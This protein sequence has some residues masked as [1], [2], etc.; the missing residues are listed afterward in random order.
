MFDSVFHGT[1][2]SG[3]L[4]KLYWHKKEKNVVYQIRIVP[5]EIM[6]M[7]LGSWNNKVKRPVQYNNY[8][9]SLTRKGM[10]ENDMQLY[11]WISCYLTMVRQNVGNI[12]AP[13]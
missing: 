11:H 1:N 7:D 9:Y 5:R 4:D 2:N 8:P 12:G 10:G 6:F 13:R 3:G